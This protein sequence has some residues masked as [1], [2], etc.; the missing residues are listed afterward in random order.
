MRDRTPNLADLAHLLEMRWRIL[1]LAQVVVNALAISL[2]VSLAALIVRVAFSLA[3]PVGSTLLVVN[4]AALVAAIF[5]IAI[6]RE[7][8]SRF[9]IDADRTYGL[10]SLLVSGYEYGRRMAETGEHAGTP[11]TTD[12]TRGARSAFERLVVEK[13]EQSTE[14]IDPRA[15]YPP[16]L[17]RRLGVVAALTVALG[18]LLILEAS[19]WFDPPQ[20]PYADELLAL[21]DAG[22]R[23]AER[24]DEDDELQQLADEMLRLGDRVRRD[25]VDANEA[26][27]RIEQLNERVEEQIR[28]LERT[29]SLE[30]NEDAEIPPE[31][32]STIRRALRSGMGEEEVLEF[33]TRMRSE[34]NTVPEAVEALEESTPDRAPDT[35]LGVDQERV[36]ELMDQLN[37]PQPEEEDAES[38]LTRELEES[39]RSLQQMGSGL[40]ELS[41]GMEGETG[42]A[43][44]E[45]TGVDRDG[46]AS[47][48]PEG[49]DGGEGEDTGGQQGGSVAVEDQTDDDYRRPEDSRPVFRE[50]QGIVTDD[51]M[52][53]VIIRELPSEATSQLT[54]QEREVAFERIVEEAVSREETPPQLRRL[55]RNYFLRLTLASE[56]G[57]EN[58]Q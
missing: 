21:E 29:P 48:P 18:I 9:L 5:V 44:G 17:P 31:A 19:G 3:F 46:Q 8:P 27:R 55:V 11:T 49:E 52:M 2:G 53:D 54:E 57:A 45:G 13:A 30:F 14:D 23:L 42:E 35:S 4:G 50:I 20:V 51:T 37:R 41:E 36:D 38:D 43:S 24:S 34:G 58:E 39:Q 26:R 16:R 7:D 47:E 1:L 32:E 6:R 56:E 33:F 40:A 22:R 28:N 15:V 25:G 12:P 10:K